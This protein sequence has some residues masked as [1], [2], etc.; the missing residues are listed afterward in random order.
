MGV[1]ENKFVY[2]FERKINIHFRCEGGRKDECFQINGSTTS[3]VNIA[4][5][6]K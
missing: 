3:L 6:I 1:N 2:K 4:I 5:N